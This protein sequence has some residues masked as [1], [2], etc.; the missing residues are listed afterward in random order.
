M[1]CLSTIAANLPGQF[2]G[3]A[4]QASFHLYRTEDVNSE[5]PIEEFNW[6]CAA[7]RADSIGADLI[8]SSLGYFDFDDPSFNYTYAQLNGNTTIAVRGADRAAKHGL[9]KYNYTSRRRQCIGHRCRYCARCG[10]I[11]FELWT[12]PRRKNQT[13]YGLGGCICRGAGQQ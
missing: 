2:V 11:F 12:C 3:K 10:W 7:E 6:V 1:Q 5:Y 9:A 13:R 4:P 8:S